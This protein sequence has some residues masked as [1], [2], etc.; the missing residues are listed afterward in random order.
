[1]NYIN[2]DAPENRDKLTQV[3]SMVWANTVGCA[4]IDEAQKLPDCFEKIKYAFDAELVPFT[5]LLGL[6]QILLLQKVRESL[7]GPLWY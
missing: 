2:L 7:A 5:V 1:L 4:I 6:S 3:S